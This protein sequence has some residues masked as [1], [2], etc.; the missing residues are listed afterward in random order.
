MFIL[1]RDVLIAT[2]KIMVRRNDTQCERERQRAQTIKNYI[3]PIIKARLVH[4]RKRVRLHKNKWTKTIK[5]YDKTIFSSPLN[6]V[7]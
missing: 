3:P 2:F 5:I 7:S 4:E 6:G 1:F